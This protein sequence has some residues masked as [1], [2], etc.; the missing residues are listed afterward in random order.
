MGQG[1]RQ[2]T[3][4]RHQIPIPGADGALPDNDR[5]WCSWYD[6]ENPGSGLHTIVICDANPGVSRHPELPRYPMCSHCR[7]YAFCSEQCSAYYQRSHRPGQF[8]KL[9]AGVNPRFFLT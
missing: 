1:G 9:P 6:C 4:V 5:I 8:G 3:R 2:V 7:R